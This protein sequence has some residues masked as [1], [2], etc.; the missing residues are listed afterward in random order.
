MRSKIDKKE[1]ILSNISNTDKDELGNFYKTTFP[2]RYKSLI[3]NWSWWYKNDNKEIEPIILLDKKKV[4]GQAAFISIK[5][6]I[7]GKII[8][9]IWFQDYAILPEYKGLG[10]GKMLCAEWM[11]IC[12]NQMA[13]CS[14]FSLR[15]LKKFNW[16]DNYENKRYVKPLN[17]TKFLPYLKKFDNNILNNIYKFF[18]RFKKS[19][20]SVKIYKIKD[21]LSVLTDAFSNQK[22]PFDNNFINIHRD[23]EWFSW[24]FVDCPYKDDIYFFQYQNNFSIV[25]IYQKENIK[26]LNIMY[27]FFT[28]KSFENEIM[29]SIISW[30]IDNNIDFVWAVSNNIEFKNVFSSM[31]TKSLKLA[32]WTE[33]KENSNCF[34]NGIFNLQGVDSDIESGL[35]VE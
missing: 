20:S 2:S 6:N 5:I 7:F 9:A 30:S 24:R 10:Y 23:L 12:P 15:V 25:H 33:K 19:K 1:I 8:K 17:F 4:I 26:R 27:N 32:T 28:D 13:I 34:E 35:Y 11:K 21:N 16:N 14:P 31:L 18:L 29:A 3:N 22:E